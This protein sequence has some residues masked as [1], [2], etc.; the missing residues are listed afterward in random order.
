[1]VDFAIALALITAPREE[2]RNASR[3]YNPRFLSEFPSLPGHPSNWHEYVSGMLP[4]A[5][6]IAP[7]ERVIVVN[8]A[9]F[10]N[11]SALIVDTPKRTLANY[12]LWR[13]VQSSLTYLNEAAREAAQDFKAV[14]KGVKRSPP[15]WKECAEFV[16]FNS[17]SSSSLR[18]PAASMY[19]KRHFSPEAKKE[20][21]DMIGYIRNAFTK[22][23][24]D[25]DWMDQKTKA[26][27]R[28]K[29]LKMDEFIGYPDELLDEE[30]VDG[31]HRG[32]DIDAGD[33]F[34][35]E[36][37]LTLWHRKYR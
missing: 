17:Y 15:R 1:M 10:A 34:G 27:A 7:D 8:P 35:N 6:D 26:K 16:G 19:V 18:I 2:R 25:L 4:G 32:V 33:F 14:L 23:I 9:Y 22:I 13:A 29:M 12:V 31:H 5:P 30:K 24:D 20:M 21:L 3:L 11:L 28:Q 36:R 37:R